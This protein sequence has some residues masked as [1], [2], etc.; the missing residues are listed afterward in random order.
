M[1]FPSTKDGQGANK[2]NQVYSLPPRG[3]G[4]ATLTCAH[5]VCC[6]Q[7]NAQEFVVEE[8]NASGSSITSGSATESR[9]GGALRVLVDTA[10]AAL[11]QPVRWVMPLAAALH[12]LRTILL[13]MQIVSE[14]QA[15]SHA[16][17]SMAR[18]PLSASVSYTCV[19]AGRS[20]V[21]GLSGTWG[22][23]MDVGAPYW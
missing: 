7:Q 1:T 14:H 20:M 19:F 4:G 3:V 22:G 15:M 16:H 12:A 23:R 21:M 18:T 9:A 2:Q 6:P 5:S 17:F 13:Y 8:R 11:Q 10:V